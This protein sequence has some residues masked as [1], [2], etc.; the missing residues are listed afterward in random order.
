MISTKTCG[1]SLPLAGRAREGGAPQ[2]ECS[3]QWMAPTPIPS[4]EERG[5][6]LVCFIV[7]LL[8]SFF[9]PATANAQY[10][11]PPFWSG[12]QST[13]GCAALDLD[14]YND[15]YYVN[16]NTTCDTSVGTTYSG[17]AN[18]I[19]GVSGS[20]TR[21]GTSSFTST[22][23]PFYLD[24]SQGQSWSSRAVTGPTNYT[25]TLQPFYLNTGY[26][27]WVSRAV[28]GPTNYT[29]TLAPFYLNTAYQAW[30]SRAVTGP[31]NYTSNLIPF[32]LNTAYQ[33]WVSRAVTTSSNYTPTAPFYLTAYETFV[34]RSGA[35][36]T[37]FNSSGTLTTA[38]SGAARTNSY[39]Y[40]GSSW[41]NSGTLVEPA[42][43][44]QIRNNTMS[45]A[46]AGSPGTLPTNWS[47][48][49]GGGLSWAVSGTGTENGI[50]YVDMHLTG[51]AVGARSMTV[52]FESLNGIA[53]SNG[54]TWTLSSYLK[55]SAGTLSNVTSVQ[56]VNSLGYGSNPVTV[57]G[58]N[59]IGTLPS[60]NLSTQPYTASGTIN[61]ASTTN[62]IP[63]VQINVTGA[64]AVDMTIRIGMPQYEQ[65]SYATSVIA[66]TSVAV[67]RNADLYNIKTSG[68]YF[69]SSGTL[70]YATTGVARTNYTYNGS[71][72]VN[73]GTLIEAA[74][75][76]LVTYSTAMTNAAWIKGSVTATGAAATAPDGTVSMNQI[77]ATASSNTSTIYE[78]ATISASTNYTL[79]CF[80]KAGTVP[81]ITLQLADNIAN[82]AG[83][84][85]H[86]SDMTL[87]ANAVGT[88]SLVSSSIQN[89][90]NG[91]YRVVATVTFSSVP[92]AQNFGMHLIDTIGGNVTS[93]EYAYIWGA[94]LESGANLTS[95]VPTLS[96]SIARS[97]DVFSET[98]S[99]TYFD[100]SGT[101]QYATT[102]VARTNYTYNGSSW[103]NSGT[104]IEPAATNLIKYST[105]LTQSGFWGGINAT[106]TP[107]A[108]TGL[109]GTTSATSIIES[110]TT[111]QHYL[112]GPGTTV[113]ASAVYTGSVYVKQI[114]SAR[115]FKFTF[116]D[117]GGNF[118]DLQINPAT[119]A[120]VSGP[121]YTTASAAYSNASYVGTLLPN[122][123]IK[124][125]FT[126]TNN[127][128]TTIAPSYALASGASF[129]YAGDGSSGLYVWG[130][131]LEAGSYATSYIPTN[132]NATFARAADVFSDTLSGTYFD[133]SG[134]MQYATTSVART[135]Y[136]YNGGS[137]VN[138]GTL[139][140]PA[141]TNLLSPSQGKF[142]SWSYGS[143]ITS[144]VDN[145]IAAPDGT[146]TASTVTTNTTGASNWSNPTTCPTITAGSSYTASMFLKAGTASTFQIEAGKSDGTDG[147]TIRGSLAS[148][149]ITST[150]SNTS[151]TYV[152]SG[153][154]ALANSWYRVWVTFQTATSTTGCI[155]FSGAAT[156]TINIWGAQVEATAYPTSYVPTV[157][158]NVTRAADVFSE[159]TS[160]TYSN[161]SGVLQY[162]TTSAARTNYTYNGSSWINSGTI[163]EPAATNL[164]KYST[165]IS[166]W[167]APV[168]I[169]VT[170][171]QTSPD[172]TVNASLIA[173]AALGSSSYVQSFDLSS[174]PAVNASATYSIYAKAGAN[175]HKILLRLQGTYPDRAD[176]L[177]DL[178]VGTVIDSSAT[179]YTILGTS[180][181]PV[182]GGWYRCSVS[183]YIA[184]TA[185]GG[186]L[187]SPTSATAAHAA[188]GNDGVLDDA[189]VWGAQLEATPFITSYV[190]TAMGAFARSADVFTAPRGGTY[191][192]TSG[193][194][195]MATAD[196]PRMDHSPVSPYASEGILIE[197]ART[198][199]VT[200]SQNIFAFNT[201][202]TTA[203]VPN[204]TSPDGTT[205]AWTLTQIGASGT[206]SRKQQNFVVADDSTTYTA[207]VY[208]AKT[209]GTPSTY[210]SLN[211]GLV[212]GTVLGR[213]VALNTQ[214]GAY[215]TNGTAS[216]QNAGNF[217][218]VS[219]SLTNNAT[220]NTTLYVEFYPA[221]NSSGTTSQSTISGG[222]AVF[223]GPQVEAASFATSYIPT[224]SAGSL[225]RPQDSFILPLPGI[226]FNSSAG[227]FISRFQTFDTASSASNNRRH[228]WA[229]ADA[230]YV[231]TSAQ[232]LAVRAVN[233]ATENAPAG[234]IG[235]G[236]TVFD[237]PPASTIAANTFGNVA[238]A[239]SSSSIP[240]AG[241]SFNGAATVTS[242]HACTPDTSSGLAI[243]GFTSG[244]TR[245]L[246]GYITRLTY[247]PI[248]QSD[249]SLPS[250]SQ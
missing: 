232:R 24:S 96:A 14:F 104:L 148:G 12:L 91:I 51:T 245:Q 223:F 173:R 40:N 38:A 6:V 16:S 154:Q 26:E 208:I 198:N 136:T 160:G 234:V 188:E 215:V 2:S 100:S 142:S 43:T 99:G 67:T 113:V 87:T 244:T 241:V 114:G 201:G 152:S 212:G 220:G 183:A 119:A 22:A 177:F 35:I 82:A 75:T 28:T 10:V 79:S 7:F 247:I 221:W 123:W 204:V 243:G 95:Y 124:V 205:D 228:V 76:N 68:T 56:L 54:Q 109:D 125:S 52:L 156:G 196:T 37:Y 69:D 230:G 127:T 162:A 225:T 202:L 206:D 143:Y 182:G 93:G 153:I 41:V 44:N 209:V 163:L 197:E 246:D 88:G 29:S 130:L 199:M 58:L 133:S 64:G 140:E 207:S 219:L 32:Y 186:I 235:D 106:V 39:T 178:N 86:L 229:I 118:L 249:S 81:Y 224:Y 248:R 172:G 171:G 146:T 57:V 128:S 59:T 147:A 34:S 239:Y 121:T 187:V 60:G 101:L 192:N 18:F 8:A 46:A 135:N 97:A 116:T 49:N 42:A 180:I 157:S 169:N 71:S 112:T 122:G 139:I 138:S 102:G 165:A 214:T 48:A 19:T 25:S 218:R 126:F 94:Q 117:G 195:K 23:P 250:Y 175:A 200:S 194:M 92:N 164:E 66:T 62:V 141:A 84:Y 90:G 77:T 168:N 98:L 193:V 115:N 174:N 80:V 227:T 45:G 74:A 222:S 85:I 83:V 231:P 134:T 189:Y 4:S 31:T 166:A 145:T 50:N 65:T 191:F 110:S 155:V 181:T 176:V 184:N 78:A 3:E 27:A 21:T 107:G 111:A 131:Q 73:S 89:V 20:F 15:K 129:N 190:P 179:S 236:T 36:A 120:I 137:W 211:L 55:L 216:V 240:G 167:G 151:G 159:T 105:A 237:I 47:A 149:T 150:F 213:V 17:I 242:A 5:I 203:A 61:D 9:F 103:V 161:S 13:H 108:G 53:A 233:Q 72:W 170:G 11:Q 210:P 238:L 63:Y 144:I 1:Y 132:S 70:Q 185:A 33:A 30:V 226:W 217:W 158:A